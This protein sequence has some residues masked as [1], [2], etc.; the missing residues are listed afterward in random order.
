MAAKRFE[1]NTE[2]RTVAAGRRRAFFYW[3]FVTNPSPG[4][5]L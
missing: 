1:K 3:P 5:V 4:I 2:S